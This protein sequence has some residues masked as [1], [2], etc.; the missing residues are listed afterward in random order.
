MAT[1]LSL[2]SGSVTRVSMADLRAGV[3]SE[4][5][6]DSEQDLHDHAIGAFP[7][8]LQARVTRADF[9]DLSANGLLGHGC[10]RSRVGA[11]RLR[12]DVRMS[13]CGQRGE[14]SHSL[15]PSPLFLLSPPRRTRL[16]VSHSFIPACVAFTYKSA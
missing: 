7:D 6:V 11:G 14:G 10:G 8:V 3:S 4:R 15:L 16:L 1:R 13:S 12:E 9:E 5:Q 2:L